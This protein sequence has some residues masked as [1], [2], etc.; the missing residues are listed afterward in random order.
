MM[1]TRE[2]TSADFDKIE[3]ALLCLIKKPQI[4]VEA[5]KYIPG[6]RLMS[7]RKAAFS[8]SESIP[9][10]KALSRIL[11]R[12]NVSCPPAIPIAVCGEEINKSAIDLF[13]YYGITEI[14]VVADF[15]KINK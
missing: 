13:N 9:V 3:N 2:I 5:P 11:A 6:K 8:P 10:E 1:F 7:V 4:T 12:D 15:S 14:E